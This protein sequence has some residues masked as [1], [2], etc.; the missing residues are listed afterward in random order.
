MKIA[1]E[2]IMSANGNFICRNENANA[3]SEFCWFNSDKKLIK[4]AE[5]EDFNYMKSHSNNSRI[6]HVEWADFVKYKSLDLNNYGDN[7]DRYDVYQD[8]ITGKCYVEYNCTIWTGFGETSS[9]D[10]RKKEIMVFKSLDE[11][12][13][14]CEKIALVV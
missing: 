5:R 9:Y 6:I 3:F 7:F 2:A 11:L 14:Y 12:N 8:T 1:V 13:D 4:R 10:Y